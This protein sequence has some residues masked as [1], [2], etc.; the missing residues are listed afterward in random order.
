MES[1]FWHY[2]LREVYCYATLVLNNGVSLC[3]IVGGLL[4]PLDRLC[5]TTQAKVVKF[6]LCGGKLTMMKGREVVKL[7]DGL[8]SVVIF[9]RHFG[10]M[11]NPHVPKVLVDSPG[12]MFVDVD[13][14]K[15]VVKYY[16]GVERVAF[17]V[18]YEEV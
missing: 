1:G 11:C 7:D 14:S 15:Y 5:R 6:N 16:D 4:S 17:L 8:I 18:A 3:C 13:G 2:S 9:D 12:A 10:A